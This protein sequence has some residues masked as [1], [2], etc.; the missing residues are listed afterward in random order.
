MGPGVRSIPLPTSRSWQSRELPAGLPAPT[1]PLLGWPCPWGPRGLLISFASSSL[2]QPRWEAPAGGSRR[3]SP[4]GAPLT[5]AV[6]RLW[7]FLRKTQR[8]PAHRLIVSSCSPRTDAVGSCLPMPRLEG[9]SP[10]LGF[11]SWSGCAAAWGRRGVSA[12]PALQAAA[13]LGQGGWVPRAQP[14]NC[15]LKRMARMDKLVNRCMNGTVINSDG[16]NALKACK[17]APWSTA[18]SSPLSTHSLRCWQWLEL[19]GAGAH[20]AL[21]PSSSVRTPRGVLRRQIREVDE[22]CGGHK[23]SSQSS[24][25]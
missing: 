21:V 20:P 8:R 13:W 22:A 5:P 25:W 15:T 10:F 16:I 18:P 23:A 17:S 4:D 24:A 19:L 1:L 2:L 11:A 9:G 3:V 12:Q 6:P 14:L 7:L